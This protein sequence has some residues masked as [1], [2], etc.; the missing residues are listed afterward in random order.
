MNDKS[1]LHER[2]REALDTVGADYE[3]LACE[4]HLADTA[5]FCA[6]YGISM[7]EACN[8][9][10]VVLKTTPRRYVACLVRADTRLDVNRK[11][12]ELTG[13]KRLSFASSEETADLTGML[14]GG[15]SIAGLPDGIPLY[16][17]QRVME[18][19]RVIIGGGNRHSKARL[20][21]AELLKLPNASVADIALPRE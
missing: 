18:R 11:V 15:V 21:P 20:A 4:P 3:V 5:E 1:I 13:V 16:V 10:L 8:A 9:I 2:V 17:D 12:S 19:P 14:I 7:D 6:H